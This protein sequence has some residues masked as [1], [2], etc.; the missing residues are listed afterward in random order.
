MTFHPVF[1]RREGD[2]KGLTAIFD[3]A[4]AVHRGQTVTVGDYYAMVIDLQRIN[5]FN[6]ANGELPGQ[7]RVRLNRV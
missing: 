4:P 7:Y 5:S 1:C 2:G 3:K 6:R